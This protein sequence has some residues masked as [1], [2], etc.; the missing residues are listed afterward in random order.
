MSLGDTG[1]GTRHNN[2]TQTFKMQLVRPLLS[3]WQTVREVYGVQRLATLSALARHGA[4]GV[5]NVA[6][7]CQLWPAATH[8]GRAALTFTRTCFR[9]ARPFQPC[10]LLPSRR[11]LQKHLSVL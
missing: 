4:Y 1:R 2:H 6:C 9:E 5:A 10:Q 8:T 7:P 11:R 3:L